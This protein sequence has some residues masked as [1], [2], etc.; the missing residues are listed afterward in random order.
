MTGSR[1]GSFF[2]FFFFFSRKSYITDI[3][4]L[5]SVSFDTA[6]GSY[7]VYCE[8]RFYYSRLLGSVE[9][10]SYLSS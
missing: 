7:G 3:A 8:V 2:L 9:R 6:K 5:A 10:S 1:S 4:R